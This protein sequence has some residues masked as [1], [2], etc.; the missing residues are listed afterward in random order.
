MVQPLVVNYLLPRLDLCHG[1]LDG[2]IAGIRSMQRVIKKR[3]SGIDK[4]L[5][6]TGAEGLLISFFVRTIYEHPF[7]Q[8]KF[9]YF[10]TF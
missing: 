2:E 7:W 4:R 1:C 8:S 3:K 6:L 9:I 5:A 10:K